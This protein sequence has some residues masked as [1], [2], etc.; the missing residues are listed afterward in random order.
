LENQSIGEI[1]GQIRVN[2]LGAFFIAHSAYP[3][4]KA[5]EGTLLN[6]S[7][8]SYS[9][10]RAKYTPYS[11]SKAGIIN[12]TQG[13]ADEWAADRVRVNCLVP[14]RTDT[15]MRRANFSDEAEDTL[16]NPFEVALSACKILSA[17]QTG[18]TVR[19]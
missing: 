3:H 1:E 18:M 14:G 4:L 13:L 2:L 17:E 11:A 19:V 15:A 16:L 12:L 5:S 7:S 9:R 10:G 6:L 8:S